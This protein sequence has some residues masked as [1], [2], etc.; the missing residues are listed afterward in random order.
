MA[1]AVTVALLAS[2]A[3]RW[4]RAALLVWT[5]RIGGEPLVG[6]TTASRG[7]AVVAYE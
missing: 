1:R 7:D 3:L 5:R 2:Q 4:P 6:Q